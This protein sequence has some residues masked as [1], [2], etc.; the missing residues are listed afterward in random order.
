MQIG[1]CV[2]ETDERGFC[3][4]CV[5]DIA[6][7]LSHADEEEDEEDVIVIGFGSPAVPEELQGEGT[8]KPTSLTK[9]QIGSVDR[10]YQRR[11][12]S[13]FG[14]ERPSSPWGG[15]APSSGRHANISRKRVITTEP[16]AEDQENE[17]E[18]KYDGTPVRPQLTPLG[19]AT[20]KPTLHRINTHALTSPSRAK[21]PPTSHSLISPLKPSPRRNL[22]NISPMLLL[23][24]EIR[25]FIDVPEMWDDMEEMHR[26]FDAIMEGEITECLRPECLGMFE[27]RRIPVYENGGEMARRVVAWRVRVD[28]MERGVNASGTGAGDGLRIQGGVVLLAP[29]RYGESSAAV[30][31]DDESSDDTAVYTPSG[32]LP[33]IGSVLGS[34]EP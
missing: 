12:E 15:S 25:R 14:I 31:V 8:V 34:G 1:H 26:K 28:Q 7:I 29:T 33:S 21:T 9:Q 11:Y 17:Q 3:D 10:E 4:A 32:T 2:E 27:S 22:A 30:D 23:G 24:H 18:P 13:E 16:N 19:L 20:F 6:S 5:A